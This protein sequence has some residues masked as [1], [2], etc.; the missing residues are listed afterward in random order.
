MEIT[1]MTTKQL[2]IEILKELQNIKNAMYQKELM[3][4]IRKDDCKMKENETRTKVLLYLKTWLGRK[5]FTK[6]Y[7]AMKYGEWI[8]VDG[9]SGPTGKT[10]LV[11][12]LNFIGYNR[13]VEANLA[14]TI[15]LDQPFQTCRDFDSILEELGIS[16][17]C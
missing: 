10:T 3:K 1:E 2:L 9:V 8:I 7:T 15:R 11:R 12:L 16:E 13:V 4:N 6:I 17:K 5:P 14:T